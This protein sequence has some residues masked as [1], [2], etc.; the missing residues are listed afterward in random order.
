MAFDWESPD[1]I[2]NSSIE[3]LN[4]VRTYHKKHADDARKKL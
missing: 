3:Q 2:K 4:N 1:S